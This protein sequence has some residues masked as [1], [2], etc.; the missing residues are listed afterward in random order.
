MRMS[1]VAAPLLAVGLAGAAGPAAAVD[2]VGSPA[3]LFVKN[4]LGAG[5]TVGDT[6]SLSDYPDRVVVLFLLE[7]N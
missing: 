6:L 7:P 5:P 4:Q 3:A 1:L 2:P